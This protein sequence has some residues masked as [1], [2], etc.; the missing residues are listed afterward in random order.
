MRNFNNF[1]HFK[2]FF[3]SFRQNP[4]YQKLT[5]NPIALVFGINTLLYVYHH[6]IIDCMET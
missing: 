5:K 1:K 3:S 4:N 2:N 6:I